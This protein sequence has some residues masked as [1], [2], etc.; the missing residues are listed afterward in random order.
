MSGPVRNVEHRR[1]DGLPAGDNALGSQLLD[2]SWPLRQ[3][4]RRQRELSIGDHLRRQPVEKV[5]P[6]EL[7]VVPKELRSHD[8]CNAG[9]GAKTGYDERQGSG[10]HDRQSV[11]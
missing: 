1:A 9:F 5:V 2:L 11:T 4:W 7:K 10:T 6:R 3:G 8:G